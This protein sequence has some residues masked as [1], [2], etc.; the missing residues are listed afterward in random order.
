MEL[1]PPPAFG[2]EAI[3]V[4]KSRRLGAVG[5]FGL[6][7]DTGDM[8]GHGPDADEQ[9][10]GDLLVAPSSRD[11]PGGCVMLPDSGFGHHLA[12]L[13]PPTTWRNCCGPPHRLASTAKSPDSVTRPHQPGRWR[14]V[15][16][17]S[18]NER[19]HIRAARLAPGGSGPPLLDCFLWIAATLRNCSGL[20]DIPAAAAMPPDSAGP[21]RFRLLELC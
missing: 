11:D 21:R 12:F 6:A 14:A 13:Y 2:S 20:P 17:H 9:F 5:S 16:Y 1:N 4:S 15:D 10:V 3:A 7:K 19:L 8:V 18:R